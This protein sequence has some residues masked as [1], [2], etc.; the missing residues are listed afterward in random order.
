MRLRTDNR[1]IQVAGRTLLLNPETGNWLRLS[2]RG[3]DLLRLLQ[4]RTDLAQA[5]AAA[6]QRG[7]FG[8]QEVDAFVH[9]LV[10][11]RFAA[12][13]ESPARRR[14]PGHA[15]SNVMLNVTHRCN[16]RCR[17]CA[18]YADP[19][20]GAGWSHL[21]VATAPAG[22]GRG[23]GLEAGAAREPSTAG[24]VRLIDRLAERGTRTLVFFGGE[25]LVRPDVRHLLSF[26][27]ARIPRVCVFTNGTLLSD[28]LCRQLARE[29]KEVRVSLDGSRPEVHDEIRGKGSFQR[30]LEGIRRL[31]HAG[32]PAVVIKTV[33][34]RRN[35]RDV[36]NMVKLAKRLGVGLDVG[37]F[38]P[39]GRGAL[40]RSELQVGAG[41]L[42]QAYQ[43]VW[44]LA[45]YYELPAASFNTFCRRFMA[46]A[47]TSCGAGCGYVLVDSSGEVFP[48]EGL[49]YWPARMGNL[50][51]ADERPLR[52]R[53][54][55]LATSVDA[56]PGCAECDLRYFCKGGCLA[57]AYV[58]ARRPA[59]SQCAFYRKVL[60]PIVGRFRPEAPSWSNLQDV[61][62]GRVELSLAREYL[63]P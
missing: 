33:I 29:T 20:S 17:H 14:A 44:L 30:T 2:G 36:P 4:G 42:L 53:F 13:D 48:C 41:P 16:L 34:T 50:L 62:E 19:G 31:R 58:S 24:L 10:W 26:A 9:T 8:A 22:V 11:G 35:A 3:A 55:S 39:L 6:R 15:V 38:V 5:A 12:R 27:A 60:P 52:P 63:A 37:E 32:H 45:D 59:C 25:P 40:H 47:G 57:E 56:F 28:E 43:C 21:A 54:G 1:T 18:V 23:P 51:R 7:G 46:R 49:Q 61:F